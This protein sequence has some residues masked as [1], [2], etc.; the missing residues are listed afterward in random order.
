MAQRKGKEM[1]DSSQIKCLS[2][3]SRCLRDEGVRNELLHSWRWRSIYMLVTLY[4]A[5]FFRQGGTL[6][7]SSQDALARIEEYEPVNVVSS[8]EN[9]ISKEIVNFEEQ[10][11]LNDKKECIRRNARAA[12]GQLMKLRAEVKEM[13]PPLIVGGVGDSGTRAVAYFVTQLGVWMGKFGVTVKKDSRDSKLFINGFK[14]VGCDSDGLSGTKLIKSFVFYSQ[15]IANCNSLNYN[16]ECVEDEM[17]WNRGVQWASSLF[18]TIANHTKVYTSRKANQMKFPYGLWGFK[19]PRSSFI[20]PHLSYVMNR[21]IRY[22]HITRDGRDI[23]AGD[24]QYFFESICKKYHSAESPLCESKY[25]NRIELWARLNLDVLSWLR[26][27]LDPS[28]YIVVRIEDLVLG[29]PVCFERLAE[30]TKSPNDRAR[31]VVRESIKLFT[32][33]ED[34]YFGRKYPTAT[35]KDYTKIIRSNHIALRAFQALGY[36]IESWKPINDSPCSTNLINVTIK[37][38]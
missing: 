4:T 12:L 7:R 10:F 5:I 3:T 15:S 26:H 24:N 30:F 18:R 11:S 34:R 23:A 16:R 31:K 36:G 14:T 19:H 28:Q 17:T 32:V 27:N 1:K 37:S 21:R 9:E 20:L 25:E 29:N 35:R 38:K 13:E 6:W 33:H 2:E 22:V 8:V